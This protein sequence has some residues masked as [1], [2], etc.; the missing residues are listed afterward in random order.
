MP[1]VRGTCVPFTNCSQHLPAKIRARLDLTERK[2]F[3][4]ELKMIPGRPAGNYLR[5]SKRLTIPIQ[6]VPIS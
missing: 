3:D 2:G 5:S 1:A 6:F 4:D